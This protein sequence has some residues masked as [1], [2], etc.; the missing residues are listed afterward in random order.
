MFFN[1]VFNYYEMNLFL[2]L[3]LDYIILIIIK[4]YCQQA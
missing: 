1:Q 3:D 2:N 4:N